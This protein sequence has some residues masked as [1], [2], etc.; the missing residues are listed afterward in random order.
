[1]TQGLPVLSGRELV[2]LVERAGWK[3]ARQSR[4]HVIM[5]KRGCPSVP[6]PLHQELKRGTLKGILRQAEISHEQ[7]ESDR[8]GSARASAS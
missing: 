1:M 5:R 6:V 8:C 2:R 7:L 4:S 3:N